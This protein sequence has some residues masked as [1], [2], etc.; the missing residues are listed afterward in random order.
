MR[1]LRNRKDGTIYEWHEILARNP[2]CEEVTEEQAFPERFIKQGV[3]EK[4]ALTRKKK[5]A[6]DLTTVEDTPPPVDFSFD[7]GKGLL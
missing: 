7:A 6:L 1:Y 3:A 2:L 4:V 5:G